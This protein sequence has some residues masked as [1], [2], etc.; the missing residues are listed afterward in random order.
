MTAWLL[1][2]YDPYIVLNFG[3]DRYP[4]RC[5]CLF[6]NVGID[7]PK[8]N[9]VGVKFTLIFLHFATCF[10]FSSKGRIDI[11]TIAICNEK[12]RK[13]IKW[14]NFFSKRLGGVIR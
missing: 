8:N 14:Q 5:S 6:T 9:C 11:T 10:S 1:R 13:Y 7:N 3:V 12:N 2:P 4:A